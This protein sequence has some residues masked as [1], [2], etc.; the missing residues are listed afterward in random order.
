M[1]PSCAGEE[2][3][4]VLGGGINGAALARELTLSGVAVAVVDAG[5]IASGATAWSTRLVH[6]GL[7]YLEHGE[8]S[9][10]RESLAE[11]D[12]LVRLAPHLV[13]P[14][15]FYLP[16]QARWGGLCSA[17]AGLVGWRALARAWRGTRGR[18]A[19][20]VGL[21][22]ALYD[23]LS[24]GSAWPRHRMVRA[25]RKGQPAVDASRFPLAGIYADA[26]MLFPERF[27][28]E[29]LLDAQQ[30]AAAAG[31]SFS[32]HT[33][34]SV[35]MTE[36]GMLHITPRQ[37]AGRGTSLRPAGIVNATGAWVDRTL[38]HLLPTLADDPQPLIGGTQGSHLV[39]RSAGLREALG[40]SG[41]YAEADDGRPVFVLPFG[42]RLVL[43]GTTDIPFSGDPHDAR[44]SAAEI[45]YLCAAV[46]RLF[47]LHAPLPEQI[48]QYYCGV[49]PLP[50]PGCSGESDATPGAITR[51][52]LLVRHPGGPVPIW[53]IVGGK[54]T[55]CRS[56][57]ETAAAEVLRCLGRPVLTTSRKR[58]LPGAP[59][60]PEPA[61]LA[62]AAASAQQAGLEPAE[63]LQAAA[64]GVALFGA[65]APLM[66]A[67]SHR[68]AG[69]G[70]RVRGTSLPMG[71]VE[72]CV[73]LEWA[74]DLEDVI[75]RRL[76]LVFA[77]GL[78][79]GTLEDVA[80]G[81]V[82]A[83]VLEPAATVAAV[84]QCVDRL[85]DRFGRNIEFFSAEPES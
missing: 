40:E 80:Q 34:S 11:R 12:R 8:V 82:E 33:H 63:A 9:L 37:A 67:E 85:R 43:V 76:M 59:T 35:R 22:L 77:E 7:R 10:V 83:G 53:S 16:V 71:I 36:D 50:G 70:K 5:D 23:L 65:R 4:V 68:A 28:V 81:L 84:R 79:R 47:P 57:A 72:A 45:A 29:L 55:T 15:E 25:G 52:H 54:L 6:G 56:L 49:R 69:G 31:T 41:V 24:V 26:Q 78:S 66:L 73:R 1:T 39:V 74:T 62:S 64:Q 60:I 27:T 20:T 38:E 44:T 42:P 14:L 19:W 46:G 18:G 51:R 2:C 21:G 3:V 13:R 58:P 32:V 30:I 75:E 48:Q 61:L 17:A